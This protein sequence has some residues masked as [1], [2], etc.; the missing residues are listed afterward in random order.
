MT[1]TLDTFTLKRDSPNEGH[2]E[3]WGHQTPAPLILHPDQCA[4]SVSE[5][6]VFLNKFTSLEAAGAV[7]D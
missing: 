7:K 2:C 5:P 3:G 1:A 6:M 4:M